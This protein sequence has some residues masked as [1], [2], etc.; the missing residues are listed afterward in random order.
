MGNNIVHAPF[1]P[2]PRVANTLPSSQTLLL[3]CST[4]M[5]GKPVGK[6]TVLVNTQLRL[7]YEFM[8]DH[9]DAPRRSDAPSLAGEFACRVREGDHRLLWCVRSLSRITRLSSRLERLDPEGNRTTQ[10]P[11]GMQ[12]RTL[13]KGCRRA[14][15]RA[16]SDHGLHIPPTR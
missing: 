13:L 5:S 11:K 9:R 15:A 16:F 10:P 1:A 6:R 4:S 14:R 12:S 3:D 8:H 7:V 2:R